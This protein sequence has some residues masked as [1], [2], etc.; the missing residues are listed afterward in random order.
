MS[1]LIDLFSRT[2]FKI[3]THYSD[4]VRK[5]IQHFVFYDLFQHINVDLYTLLRMSK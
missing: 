2:N 5:P 3:I 1:F 4:S